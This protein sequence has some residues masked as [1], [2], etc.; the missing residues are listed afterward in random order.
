MWIIK[1]FPKTKGRL[2]IQKEQQRNCLQ[3]LP[4]LGF[5]FFCLT[6]PLLH[7]ILL[8]PH[9][10]PLLC[11][12]FLSPEIL[13]HSGW[14]GG[15]TKLQSLQ[16]QPVAVWLERREGSGRP[17]GEKWRQKRK[18]EQLLKQFHPLLASAVHCQHHLSQ[19]SWG[20]GGSGATIWREDEKGGGSLP[21]GKLILPQ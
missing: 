11:L 2:R 16:P 13:W 15:G 12:Q 10:V 7:P 6:S 3:L 14:V 17:E 4:P 5:A 8:E 9:Y 19:D 20:D 1:L 21:E 18:R